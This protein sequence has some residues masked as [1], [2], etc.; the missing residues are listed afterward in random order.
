MVNQKS[1]DH[2]SWL[3][4][5]Y[6][7]FVR[8]F[9]RIYYR[10]IQVVGRENVTLERPLLLAPNHQNALM[11]AIAILSTLPYQPVFYARSDIFRK[12]LVIRILTF[13]KIMPIYRIRDGISNVKRN[14]EMFDK[15]LRVLENRI[16]PLCI[17]PEGNHGD[18]RRLRPLV[19]GIFR[20]AFAAQEKYGN[21]PGIRIVPVG[22]DWSHYIHFRSDVLIQYGQPI[23]LSEYYQLYKTNPVEGINALKERLERE[24]SAI[25]IDIR[26]LD[27]YDTIER[28]RSL[29]TPELLAQTGAGR[30][31]AERLIASRQVVKG[32]NQAVADNR[33]PQELPETVDT[34]YKQLSRHRLR[35]HSVRRAPYSIM[36]LLLKIVLFTVLLPV[37]L[38]GVVT[39][40]LP[41]SL[42][43]LYARKIKDTQFRSSFKFVLGIVFFLVWYGLLAIVAGLLPIDGKVKWTAFM[44]APFTGVFAIEY[45][46]FGKK[47]VSQLRM[48]VF[49][50]FTPRVF[51]Q[52]KQLRRQ[53]VEQTL[54][55]V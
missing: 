36:A 6:K 30:T 55:T 52:L 41:Y 39:N 21:S 48:T 9:F 35:D 19:K 45:Y 2:F 25:M 8:M 7:P 31:L 42:P 12:P 3:Y 13:L 15:G 28:I 18:K 50:W 46:L 53:I 22:I 16:S 43:V 40:Y 5:F 47:L 51:N 10:R 11:D 20:L 38:F 54:K 44:L 37:H 33:L 26:P 24:M 32:L 29:V 23:E 49:R 17:M 1:I 14:D 34:Y 27:A 4:A